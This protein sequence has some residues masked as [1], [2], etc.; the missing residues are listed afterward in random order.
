MP[1]VV[2]LVDRRQR[3]APVDRGEP[4]GVAVGEHVDRP[5]GPWLA[6][7]LDQRQPVVADGGVDR[8]VLVAHLG[9]APPGGARARVRRRA[10]AARVLISSSAQR[11]L[12]A[13]GRAASSRCAAARSAGVGGIVAQRQRHRRRRRRRSGARRAPASSDAS[14]ICSA[15]RAGRARRCGSRV[16]SMISTLA[17]RPASGRVSCGLACHEC[18]CRIRVCRL[19]CVVFPPG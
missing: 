3:R 16:W 9:G 2:R 14:A 6:G 18:S 7:A 10:G 8:H 15:V 1:V 5:A 12:T 4:A 11:R 19:R 13:V 17:P